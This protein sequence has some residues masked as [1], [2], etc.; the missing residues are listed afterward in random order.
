MTEQENTNTE[1]SKTEGG[2]N[3]LSTIAD[4][5]IKGDNPLES[6]VDQEFVLEP[7]ITQEVPTEKKEEAV[8]G[9]AE[10]KKEEVKE[11]PTEVKT[12]P[13]AEKKEIS[14]N[15]VIGK[16]NES[17]GDDSFGSVEELKAVI[18]E[19]KKFKKADSEIRELA[20]EERA[21]LEVGRE[22]GDYGLYDR[23]LNIDTA[24]LSHKEALKQVFFLEK[25]G[26]NPMLIEKLFEKD[27]AKTYEDET[28]EETSK[29][30]LE[31]NGQEAIE[32]I[33]DLQND[34]KKLGQVSGGV[35]PEKE[36]KARIE[37]DNKWFTAVDS[38][39]EKTDRVTYDLEDGL[40]INIVMDAKDKV[41]IQ[42]AMDRPI[43]F[44]KSMITDDNGKYDHEA[45]LEF[46][47]RNWYYEQALEEARKS[48]AALR[49]EKIL[50]EKK[51]SVIE[52]GKAG[53]VISEIP[54]VE[55]LAKG[56][57]QVFNH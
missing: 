22:Y 10:G 45:L 55:A 9:N 15:E 48:G 53:D 56:L 5:I 28:D 14:I 26:K 41:G 30:L 8:E 36:K 44:L 57:R 47:L 11:T 37:E 46:V 38:V 34:F 27:Y 7:I 18:E 32:K 51:N 12:E 31:D 21:R 24:K 33:I 16:L 6:P 50:K 52:S 29:M 39:L 2:T 20:Q 3:I 42:D 49:E 40:K 17:L 23:V 54:Q 13:I 43:E 35:D 4:T 25:A 1:A 19:N